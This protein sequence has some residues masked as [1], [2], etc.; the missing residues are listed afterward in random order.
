MRQVCY[1]QLEGGDAIW[2]RDDDGIERRF[3]LHADG[4]PE[5]NDKILFSSGQTAPIQAWR[6]GGKEYGG[7][8]YVRQGD[9]AYVDGGPTASQKH[10]SLLAG[11]RD[12]LSEYS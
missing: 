12:L 5:R 11:L 8:I 9:Y 1:E 2:L 3:T 4:R 10:S 6:I 7:R